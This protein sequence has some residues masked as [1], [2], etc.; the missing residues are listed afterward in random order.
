MCVF[1]FFF[2]LASHSLKRKISSDVQMSKETV[3]GFQW[4]IYNCSFSGVTGRGEGRLGKRKQMSC[5]RRGKKHPSRSSTSTGDAFFY[6]RLFPVFMVAFE[7]S[8]KPYGCI[9]VR[10][11]EHSRL[12]RQEPNGVSETR[13]RNTGG[14]A[15]ILLCLRRPPWKQR[16]NTDCSTMSPLN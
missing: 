14:N 13:Q 9:I 15:A 8:V 6:F 2:F 1:F 16:F 10:P 7:T 5:W 12:A 3:R 11:P 4:Q